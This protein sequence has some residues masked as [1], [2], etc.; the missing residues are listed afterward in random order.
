M[1]NKA[2][3]KIAMFVVAL[4]LTTCIQE[5]TNEEENYKEESNVRQIGVVI[6]NF[7]NVYD[8]YDA[9]PTKV[10]SGK[11]TTRSAV[12][13]SDD[14][15]DYQFVW[16][17]DDEI[18]IFP[19]KGGQVAFPMA[20]GAGTQTA[21]FDGGGWGLK[22][23]A[24]YSAYYPVVREF[25]LDKNDIPIDLST[26]KQKGNANHNHIGKLAYMSA[27]NSTVNEEGQVSF[28]FNYLISVLHLKITVPVPGKYNRLILMAS[29]NLTTNASL[30]LSTGEV[31]NRMEQPLQML[32]L[33]DVT[34]GEVS[35]PLEVY[36]VIR[37]ID[38]TDKIL[39][40]RIYAEDGSVYVISLTS[41]N[42]E[43]GNFYHSARTAVID[44]SAI[45]GLP[46]VF[47]NTPVLQ[48]EINKTDWV[49][50]ASMTILLP[51]GTIDYSG[52]MQ[53]KGRGNTT[54][55]YPKKPY[56]IKLDAKAKILGMS[57]HKRWCLMANWMDRTLMR[58]AV[59]FEIARNTDLAWT[60]S[61]KY[62][63]MVFNGVHVGNYYLCEQIKVDDKRV[64]IA[65]L[66]LA[67]TEG[68]GITGGFVFEIDA[69]Y[70]EIYKFRPT[71]SNLPWMFKDPGEVN[72]AQYNWVVNYVNEMEDALYDSTKFA[73][74]EFA[75]YMELESYVDYWIV[76]ELTMNSEMW[77]PKSCYMY[78]DANGKLTAGPVWD[79]DWG[80]FV[81]NATSYFRG[82]DY[83]YYPQLFKDAAFVAMV[84]SRW[85]TFKSDLET[86][87][88]L[89]IE[90]TR[91]QLKKSDAVNIK[92][93]PINN[94]QPNG[95]EKMSYDEA[96]N[97]LK[98]AYLAKL[99]WLDTQIKNM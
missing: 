62:V 76:N 32:E 79:Y 16:A 10:S 73:N 20:D 33:Q 35:E 26:Q 81:P 72:E 9:Q 34:V 29:D 12:H 84:K 45:T 58:N 82:K 68:P 77:Y 71:R 50:G 46:M 4:F 57:K 41:R 51:D 19:N 40:A 37:P 44:N 74:R 1:M 22:P 36:M 55:N 2:I 48:S 39:K 94:G 38:L 7:G 95:D 63:E 42:Y 88:P 31:E 66:D 25:D 30:N 15:M 23:S 83:M 61:G 47:V 52:S 90:T 28:N 24:T 18:G 53:I 54:W 86:K 96:V 85:A 27:I 60:P 56:N 64:N 99:K 69:N 70:D 87:V 6:P 67:A 98:A 92:M 91:T 80:T 75:D 89:F 97:R 17:E 8:D 21:M 49:D 65:E 14:G 93:W 5:L 3:S 43:A 13:V 78:K 11:N 59:A